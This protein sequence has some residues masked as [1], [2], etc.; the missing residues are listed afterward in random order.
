M[1]SFVSVRRQWWVRNV[2]LTVF[3]A[4]QIVFCSVSYNK[5]AAFQSVSVVQVGSPSLL[6]SNRKKHDNQY[7]FPRSGGIS[8]GSTQ[9]SYVPLTTRVR[10]SSS[11]QQQ[12]TDPTSEHLKQDI[13]A[14]KEEAANRL[15]SLLQQMDE[16]KPLNRSSAPNQSTHQ[17]ERSQS[18]SQSKPI[19]ILDSGTISKENEDAPA[20]ESSLT[21]T[22]TIA[23]K[24]PKKTTATASNRW[25]WS[26][27]G[28]WRR[29]TGFR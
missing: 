27:P 12:A 29:R 19:K 9:T 13:A 8:S 6:A 11:D 28:T 5:V 25:S 10:S 17:T 24:L 23:A 22:S 18:Y 21:A 7:L 4:S 3:V 16:L 1:K 15:D 26:R 20:S 14:L 2:L